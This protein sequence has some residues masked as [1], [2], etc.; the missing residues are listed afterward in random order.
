MDKEQIFESV[1]LMCRVNHNKHDQVIKDM[2]E[3][4]DV[5]L[6]SKVTGDESYYDMVRSDKLYTKAIKS[7]VINE[8]TRPSNNEDT[9]VTTKTASQAIDYLRDRVNLDRFFKDEV[10]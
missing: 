5:Y 6:M 10:V 7:V 8:Y 9:G 1:K 2:I 4:A 3:E